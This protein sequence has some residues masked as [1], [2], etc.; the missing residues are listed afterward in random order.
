MSHP[1]EFGAG[2]PCAEKFGLPRDRL[3]FV[4]RECGGCHRQFKVRL[5]E[6]D[7]LMALR[8]MA[9]QVTHEN[10][11][12]ASCLDVERRCPYCGVTGQDDDWFTAEQRAFID[13]RAESLNQEIR[14]EILAQCERSLSANPYLTFLPVR[15]TRSDAELKAEPDDMRVLPLLCCG[16]EVKIS[17]NWP[18]PLFCFY[19]GCE[20]E[21]F[22][23]LVRLRVQAAIDKPA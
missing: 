16:E 19:C 3:N 12:E 23:P 7:G 17:E 15:P 18:G 14:Y 6:L 10:G 8:R 2:G 11:H 9:S 20:H 1:E 13:K 21:L 4:R 22:E 5:T